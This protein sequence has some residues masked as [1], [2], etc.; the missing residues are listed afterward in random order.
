MFIDRR[1]DMIGAVPNMVN[2]L[3][4]DIRYVFILKGFVL[5]IVLFGQN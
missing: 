5:N 1:S 4:A 3:L 2:D